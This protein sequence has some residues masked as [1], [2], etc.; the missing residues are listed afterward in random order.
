MDKHFGT[1][2][3]SFW[4]L[5]KDDQK[6]I[7]DQVLENTSITAE[8]LMH[9]LYENNYPIMQAVK[10]LNIPL[11]HPIRIPLEFIINSKLRKIL[12]RDEI[13]LDE[14]EKVKEEINRLSVELDALTLNFI[15]TERITSLME[16]LFRH[17]DDVILMKLIVDLLKLLK[18]LPLTLD[19][20]RSENL[21]FLIR[22][23]HYE[24]FLY[25][26]ERGDVEAQTW[27]DLFNTLYETL[28]MK[29]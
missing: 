12:E 6:K 27:I 2:S 3:Y 22:R 1:H 13:N 8:S 23:I 18:E 21:C 26:S 4:H 29:M 19:L 11:P 20:W 14:L 15:A 28:N 25:K 24:A 5:F 16:Q 7:V 17:S 9:Q 10:E